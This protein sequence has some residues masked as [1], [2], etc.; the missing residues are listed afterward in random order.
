MGS[1]YGLY[2]VLGTPSKY[3]ENSEILG[4]ILGGSKNHPRVG[5]KYPLEGQK[6]VILQ[7]NWTARMRAGETQNILKIVLSLI[8]GSIYRLYR[9]H[10]PL[11]FKMMSFWEL[12]WGGC[13]KKP[14]TAW[15]VSTLGR[16]IGQPF[17][18]QKLAR[19]TPS[20]ERAGDLGKAPPKP[21]CSI[22]PSG[23]EAVTTQ[24]PLRSCL[25]ESFTTLPVHQL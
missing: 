6:P 17:P 15:V 21:P 5:S 10:P 2:R 13:V 9:V 12:F 23:M 24:R 8:W 19:Y 14:P 18:Q 4:V 16:E 7:A 11:I 20:C 22:R 25:C 3:Y 1:I